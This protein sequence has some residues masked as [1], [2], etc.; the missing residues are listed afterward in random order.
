MYNI[1]GMYSIETENYTSGKLYNTHEEL[2]NRNA[3]DFLIQL[4]NQLMELAYIVNSKYTCIIFCSL[5][6]EKHNI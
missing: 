4:C 1:N 5:K 6:S 2:S 3:K